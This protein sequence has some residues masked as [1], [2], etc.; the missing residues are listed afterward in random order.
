A[1]R[2]SGDRRGH[3]PRR[4]GRRRD[5]AARRGA[6]RRAPPRARR[7]RPIGGRTTM[8]A[9]EIVWRP[10]P[11]TASR[12]RIARFMRAPGIATLEELQRR[13]VEDLD[14]YWSAVVKDLGWV[15]TTPYT[16]VVDV[17]RGI[18]WPHWFPGGR[19]NLTAQCVD[20]HVAAGRGDKAAVI[21]E[22]EDGG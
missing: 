12:T 8:D 11:D 16:A 20:V 5:G 13:S 6:G 21:S 18:A 22:A 2:P 7:G 14:W 15:W 3:E 10:D 17:A 19:M 4:P 9:T 1:G